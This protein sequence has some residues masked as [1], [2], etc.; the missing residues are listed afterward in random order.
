M[1]KNI[2]SQLEDVST[3]Q[4]FRLLKDACKSPNSCRTI[5]VPRHSLQRIQVDSQ[6]SQFAITGGND[7][8]LRYWNLN[9]ASKLSFQVNT[10]NDDEVT[11]MSERLRET[12]VI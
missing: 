10:P 12:T 4:R 7:M 9:D 3:R 11:Y 5:L 8:K 2:D 6:T 1:I